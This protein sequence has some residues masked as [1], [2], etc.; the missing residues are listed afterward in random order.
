MN[1][2]KFGQLK[3]YNQVLL[4][5]AVLLVAGNLRAALTSVG[6]IIGLLRE[7]LS[8]SNGS[9]GILTSLPLIAFAVM[10]PHCSQDQY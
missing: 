9:I 6:P 2:Y 1:R 8:L 4:I 3:S 10:S 5:S 7:S